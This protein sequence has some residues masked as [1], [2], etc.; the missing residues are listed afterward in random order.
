MAMYKKIYKVD[1]KYPPR[2]SSNAHRL[3]MKL[4]ALNPNSRITSAKTMESFW[5]KKSVLKSMMVMKKER[6]F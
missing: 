3:S 2:F 6:S 5:F 1:F 4:L